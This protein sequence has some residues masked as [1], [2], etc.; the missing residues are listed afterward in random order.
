M[1]VCCLT[2]LSPRPSPPPLRLLVTTILLI[3]P[4]HQTLDTFSLKKPKQK[5]L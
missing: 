5:M 1:H 3:M 4:A 2:N